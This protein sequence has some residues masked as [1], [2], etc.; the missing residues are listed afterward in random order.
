MLTLLLQ[1]LEHHASTRH[2]KVHLLEK[3]MIVSSRQLPDHEFERAL[4]KG[5]LNIFMRTESLEPV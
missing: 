1:T 5:S 3:N 4:K 2:C